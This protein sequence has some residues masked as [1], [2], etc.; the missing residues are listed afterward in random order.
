VADLLS[1]LSANYKA[2]G[3]TVPS[4]T[5]YVAVDPNLYEGSWSGKYADNKTFNITISGVS[6]FR[7]KVHYQSG[8]TSKYQD[9]LIKD[10]GFRIA[11]T[12]FTLLQKGTALIKNVVSDPATG[13]SYLDQ[14]YARQSI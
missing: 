11:D 8:G 4:N 14:A 2:V 12:K 9:V 5:P 7:A 3:L 13:S 1:I 10:N 6:G